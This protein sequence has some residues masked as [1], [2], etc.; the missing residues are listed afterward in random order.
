V[1]KNHSTGRE[2]GIA[3]DDL[4][5]LHELEDNPQITVM[6]V[7]DARKQGHAEDTQE[8][9]Q[10]VKSNFRKLL[11]QL[12][13]IIPVDGRENSVQ[14]DDPV[15]ELE[16]AYQAGDENAQ[17]EI[18]NR[19]SKANTRAA[20][21]RDGEDRSR[22]RGP[23]SSRLTE[24]GGTLAHGAVNGERR[25][26]ITLSAQ[27]VEAAKIAGV[28]LKTYAENVLRLR[29]AKENGDYQGRP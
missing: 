2:N 3:G 13:R 28:D 29:E 26:R 17:A 24:T 9:H 10:A 6:A 14:S 15:A 27:Q 11:P 18:T 22:W 5:Y 4:Q 20:K 1:K 16:D 19:I 8:F 21:E 25:G 12:N 7:A 23:V